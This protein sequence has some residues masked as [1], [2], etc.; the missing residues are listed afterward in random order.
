MSRVIIAHPDGRTYSVTPEAHE[1][2]Y[3]AQGFAVVHPESPDDFVADVP[4]PRPVRRPPAP[5][6][7]RKAAKP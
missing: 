5:K 1:R 2:I 6:R 3:A 7:A 4:A